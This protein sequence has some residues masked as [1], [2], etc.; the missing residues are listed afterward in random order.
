MTT[1]RSTRPL[2]SERERLARLLLPLLSEF[3]ETFRDEKDSTGALAQLI[4]AE[5]IAAFWASEE[6]ERV[7]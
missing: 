6:K 3:V 1:R 7:P 5:Q 2:Y 4:D